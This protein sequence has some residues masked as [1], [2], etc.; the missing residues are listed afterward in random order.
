MEMM[1]RAIRLLRVAA[2]IK[3]R[4]LAQMLQVS[5]N[6][7]SMVEGGNRQPSFELLE[8]I[9]NLFGTKASTIM[10]CAEN[11]GR[12]GE[13]TLTICLRIPEPNSDSTPENSN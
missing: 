3:Q 2:G 6:Y 7:M 9:A 5:A 1:G 12:G 8:S 4:K 13:I 10:K 11:L